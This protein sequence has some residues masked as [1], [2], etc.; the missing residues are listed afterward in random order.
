MGLL[1]WNLQLSSFHARLPGCRRDGQ[2]KSPSVPESIDGRKFPQRF[3]SIQG[4]QLAGYGKSRLAFLAEYPE[5][6]FALPAASSY[7]YS[8]YIQPIV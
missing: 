6:V 7:H 5:P 3:A 8:Q 2:V 4:P 1:E